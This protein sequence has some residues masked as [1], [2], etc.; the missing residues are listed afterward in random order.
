MLQQ[1]IVP[2]LLPSAA[3]SALT[4]VLA[5]APALTI[6]LLGIAHF[7]ASLSRARY[8]HKRHRYQATIHP[9]FWAAHDSVSNHHKMHIS[10]AYPCA[11]HHP[12]ALYAVC[13]LPA[14]LRHAQHRPNFYCTNYTF[15]PSA[16]P[17]NI[18][19]FSH[20]PLP[21]PFA[22]KVHLAVSNRHTGSN[23]SSEMV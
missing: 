23:R 9:H 17:F 18:N 15:P 13:F 11:W 6:F 22:D 2:R 19:N 10:P 4:T 21:L 1:K 3:V 20:S 8:N 14:Q 7:L 16:T 5:C 12:P